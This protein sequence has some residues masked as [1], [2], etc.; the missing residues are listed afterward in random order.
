MHASTA[1][2]ADKPSTRADA[3]DRQPWMNGVDGR[4]ALEDR[5]PMGS[6]K[7][8]DCSGDSGSTAGGWMR[9]RILRSTHSQ[10]MWSEALHCSCQFEQHPGDARHL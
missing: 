4:R 10:P 6:V 2:Q 7:F 9:L 5:S 8:Q 3:F 1:R